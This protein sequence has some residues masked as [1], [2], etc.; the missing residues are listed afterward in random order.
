MFWE[1]NS[2]WPLHILQNSWKYK[3]HN[4]KKRQKTGKRFI[5][6]CTLLLYFL[7]AKI[8]AA[9]KRHMERFSVR[10]PEGRWEDS[11][12]RKQQSFDSIIN[13]QVLG[14]HFISQS[15]SAVVLLRVASPTCTF[16][17]EPN[18]TLSRKMLQAIMRVKWDANLEL[19]T[20]HCFAYLAICRMMK[21][22][23]FYVSKLLILRYTLC[24][25]THQRRR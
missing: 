4:V 14:K 3:K 17:L 20:P 7:S 22:R 2:P 10:P 23:D 9:V 6:L 5:F 15:R 24:F 18:K 21:V 16:R 8:A 12:G 13:Q 1:C 25:Y 19:L 11:G